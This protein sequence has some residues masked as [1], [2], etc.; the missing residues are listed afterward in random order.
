MQLYVY[1]MYKQHIFFA[2]ITLTKIQERTNGNVWWKVS[3]VYISEVF[4]STE[5]SEVKAYRKTELRS[6]KRIKTKQSI[7][8]ISDEEDD[9]K[10]GGR[11]GGSKQRTDEEN[12]NQSTES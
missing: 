3:C 2:H 10:R 6:F 11:R 5:Y 8:T 4:E 7:R 12:V 1:D 9:W